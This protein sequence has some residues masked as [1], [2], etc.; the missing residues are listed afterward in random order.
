MV[1]VMA[2]LGSAS[3]FTASLSSLPARMHLRGGAG[4]SGGARG[5]VCMASMAERIESKLSKVRTSSPWH[6]HRGMENLS[7]FLQQQQ[8]LEPCFEG[9]AIHDASSPPRCFALAAVEK[10]PRS[11]I[12]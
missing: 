8:Q 3:A 7:H 2:M 9:H 11:L 1:A 4:I 12:D 10:L 6:F 5:L